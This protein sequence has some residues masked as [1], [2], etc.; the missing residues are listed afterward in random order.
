LN[1]QDDEAPR[2]LIIDI[3]DTCLDTLTAFVRWLHGLNR[4]K[5]VDG[6][7]I[8]NRE[9]LGDWLNVPDDL[10]D[11]WMNEFCEHTWQ[12]GALYPM[13]GSDQIIPQLA[14]SGWTIIGY[15]K[16]SNEMHRATLRRANLELVMPGA[17][18]ELYVV[19][20]QVNLYPLLKE[21]DYAVCVTSIESTAI[22][23]AHAG[24]ATY[25]LKQPWN[26]GLSNISIRKF[27]DW[28]E[29]ADA[30]SKTSV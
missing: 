19:N 5:G 27:N 2:K 6:N 21:H 11:L 8:T 22:A 16:S 9:K 18:R 3:D 24:H 12:W 14:K 10:A 7:Q 23:S 1:L 29:I 26:H 25:M 28:A 13:F 20:R 17:F 30:L 15:T 4:L